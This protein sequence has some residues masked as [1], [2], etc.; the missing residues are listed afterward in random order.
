MPRRYYRQS[1]AI[2]NHGRHRRL[3]STNLRNIYR[4]RL[5]V[6]VNKQFMHYQYRAYF[7]FARYGKSFDDVIAAAVIERDWL[8]R[9]RRRILDRLQV[10]VWKAMMTKKG[11]RRK[12]VGVVDIKR[13][14]REVRGEIE[15]G[16]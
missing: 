3:T 10:K 5:G 14:V 7:S 16:E 12:R 4:F 13:V 6:Y 11:R 9:H 15:R 2:L 1:P 8:D